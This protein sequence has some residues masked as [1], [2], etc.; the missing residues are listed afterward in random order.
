MS[1]RYFPHEYG[2]RKK[3][4]LDVS[5]S[6]HN[7]PLS[8][9]N[10]YQESNKADTWGD[11]ND[12]EM[13]LLASQACEEACNNNDISQLANYTICMQPASTSTQICQPG[14]SAKTSFVFKKPSSNPS[15][16][17]S[18][19]LKDKC[20]RISSPLP[21]FSSKLV[22]KDT[23][24]VNQTDDFIFND[25]IYKGQ[26]SN[27][28]YQQLLQMQEENA[29]LKSENGK[30][31]EKCLTK[32]GE[33]SILRTQLKNCQMSVDNARL[34]KIKAQ[35]KVQMEYNEKLN[36]ANNQ[37]HDLRTQLDFKN[38]EIISIKE[39]CKK[40]ESTKLKLT[41]VTV[42]GNDISAS[43]KHINN[44]NS[45]DY[46]QVKRVKTTCSSVQTEDKVKFLKL[47]KASRKD[48]SKLDTVLPYLLQSA[49]SQQYSLLDYN[50]KLQKRTD[51]SHNK[52]RIYS[53]FLRAPST[54][55][56]REGS[57]KIQ[58]NC[59]YEDLCCIA[60]GDSDQLR[61]FN[62]FTTIKSSLE[63]VVTRL[64]TICRR[65]TSAFQKEMD[66]KY[67]ESSTTYLDVKRNELLEGRALYKE[68]QEILAR[69]MTAVLSYV[70]ESSRGVDYYN[71]FEKQTAKEQRASITDI[72]SR[73][74]ELLDSTSCATMYSGLLLSIC[75]LIQIILSQTK[76]HTLLDPIKS[77]ITARAMPFVYC[78]I[79]GTVKTISLWENFKKT[80]CPGSNTGNLKIDYDQGVLLCKKDSC[81][82]QTLWKHVE[83]CLK[84]IEKQNLPESAVAFTRDLLVLHSNT[85]EGASYGQDKYS[86][87]CQLTLIQVVVYALRIC[88]VMLDSHKVSLHDTSGSSDI[89]QELLSVCRCGV[90][91]LYQCTIKDVEFTTQLS[92]N[93]GHLIEFCEIMKCYEHS[94]VY[95]K[96]IWK[97][98]FQSYY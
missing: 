56:P 48:I 70:L 43:N 69:R 7:F 44:Y 12:D 92:Y 89:F 35:E 52:C 72:I 19:H 82:L 59:V 68:E 40:L 64:E 87:D 42:S 15:S 60:A 23:R 28:V 9:N 97:F 41:Q 38:L 74:C 65:M 32:E 94:E 17:L 79:L 8:Q 50:E 6:D 51:L 4:K 37:M 47:N 2:D 14:P 76:N 11:E 20:D 36:L 31:L 77:V 30:L 39:K 25:K 3:A 16:T 91:A 46:T 78:N 24:S 88:S 85:C 90:Q 27:V 93:E 84:C 83:V 80:F 62:V 34:E 18:T 66:E 53:T 63:E 58:T 98:C 67:I 33:A 49:Q 81:Y 21:G 54:P 29:K 10:S 86:C 5:I 55:L 13:L 75:I 57:F 95:C 26:D 45:N 71:N 61:Y 1:K 73:I 96:C 22:G